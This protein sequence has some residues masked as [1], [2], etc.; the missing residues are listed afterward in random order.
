MTIMIAPPKSISS[1]QKYSK[2]GPNTD[3]ITLCFRWFCQQRNAYV[4]GSALQSILG[5]KCKLLLCIVHVGSNRQWRIQY[6]ALHILDL[7]SHRRN[8]T[9]HRHKLRGHCRAMDKCL[10]KIFCMNLWLEINVFKRFFWGM[11]IDIF[12]A[13]AS[14]KVNLG[15]CWRKDGILHNR[16]KP[17]KYRKVL[18]FERFASPIF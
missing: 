1:A 7:S 9:D 13:F 10:Q 5:Y 2:K 3:L 14:I 4:F 15:L 6:F 11:R 16:M 8:G 17:N 12:R 18:A